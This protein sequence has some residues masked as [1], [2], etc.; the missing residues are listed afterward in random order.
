MQQNG[1]N[2]LTS[3]EHKITWNLFLE[4]ILPQ[5]N[6]YKIIMYYIVVATVTL[7]I[8]QFPSSGLEHISGKDL[9]KSV[10]HIAHDFLQ[11]QLDGTPHSSW[12]S[13]CHLV[14]H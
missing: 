12:L 4:A 2:V 9:L 6:N 13:D 1:L 7:I 11:Y 8:M 10:S 14:W 5:L 3:S